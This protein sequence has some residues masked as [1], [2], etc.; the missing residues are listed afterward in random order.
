MHFVKYPRTISSASV[1]SYHTLSFLFAKY[2]LKDDRS[3]LKSSTLFLRWHY[4]IFAIFKAMFGLSMFPIPIGSL[5][6]FASLYAG[7]VMRIQMSGCASGL[8]IQ[9]MQIIKQWH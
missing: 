9:V 4:V 8:T 3:E 5:K 7:N 1:F 6:T 2:L